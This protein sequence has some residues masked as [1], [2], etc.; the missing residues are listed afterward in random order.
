[1]IRG[2]VLLALLVFVESVQLTIVLGII[3]HYIPFGVDQFNDDLFPVYQ[4]ALKRNWQLEIY[5]LFIMVS[6]MAQALVIYNFRRRI[7]EAA[8]QENIKRLL[9]VDTLWVFVQCY[10][11]FKVLI[12]NGPAWAWGLFYTS[13]AASLLSRV[14]WVEI[15]RWGSNL[16]SPSNVS[17]GGPGFAQNEFFWIPSLILVESIQVL[18]AY[19]FLWGQA[20]AGGPF[21]LYVIFLVSLGLFS[22][23][24]RAKKSYYFKTKSFI[25]AEAIITFLLLSALYKTVIYDYRNQL[26]TNAY[27]VLLVMALLNKIFWPVIWDACKTMDAF[28]KSRDNARI[29]KTLG[30]CLWVGLIAA[31]IYLPDPQA[32]L[33]KMFVGEQFHHMNHFIMAPGWAYICGC[34]LDVDVIS[35]YGI[36]APIVLSTLAKGLGGFSYLN[37]L[38]VIMWICLIYYVL[39]YVFLRVWLKSF[40]LA[41]AGILIGIKLQMF[42]TLTLPQPLTY[43]SATPVRFMGDILFMFFIWGHI[44]SRRWLYLW[45]ASL[46]C[47]AAI[48]YMMETGLY[49]TI[50]LGAYLIM[51]GLISAQR[52]EMFGSGKGRMAAALCVLTV[53]LGALLFFWMA[54]GGHAFTASFWHNIFEFNQYFTKGLIAGSIWAGLQNGQF[55][56]LLVGF[57]FPTVYVLTV[58]IIGTLCVLGKISKKHLMVIVWC[59]YGLGAHHYYIVLATAN[60]YYM[61]AL[62]FVFVCLYW[63]HL[64]FMR[65]H[66]DLR[67][68]VGMF[69]IALCVYALWTNHHFLSYPN[70]FNFSRNP[71]VDPL[72]AEELPTRK[73]YLLHKVWDY[74]QALKL[75]LNSLGQQDEGLRRDFASD[76]E[77]KLYYAQESYFPKDAQLIQTLTISQEPVALISSFEIDMLMQAHRKPLFYYFSLT[78]SRPMRMRNF[79]TA[80]IYTHGQ[81]KMLIDQLQGAGSPYVFMERIF[82]DRHFPKQ[83]AY[84]NPGLIGLL[85]Y[86]NDHYQPY[87]YGKFLVAM[88]RL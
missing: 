26:A 7:E 9:C 12:Y 28:L 15:K 6:I 66:R 50:A 67:Q 31:I 79:G 11:V 60:N 43:A 45:L 52:P 59:V 8:F 71:M 48:F 51:N 33:A 44:N 80:E 49:L 63:V 58:L 70:M 81:L 75:P 10:A 5:H 83:Y 72:V 56:D 14:F 20:R 37:M 39:C 17:I 54:V 1:M 69:L 85:S 68:R 38:R 18:I 35:R 19:N 61:R 13:L 4:H 40:T 64:G 46:T 86:V 3:S 23:L 53:P 2:V 16:L 41:A 21:L 73:P 29:L 25:I 57:L 47:A 36:G 78:F 74:P 42:Y 77:L 82:L 87:A 34:V 76:E 84:D 24:S 30:D 88:K 62:P 32:V 22:F 55:W 27:H 65:L